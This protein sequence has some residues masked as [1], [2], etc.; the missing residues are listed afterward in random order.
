[1]DP[2]GIIERANHDWS[3]KLLLL[4]LNDNDL[5]DSEWMFFICQEN[6][7]KYGPMTDSCSSAAERYLTAHCMSL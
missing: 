6:T 5:K 1:M 3:M 2:L 7:T 4:K